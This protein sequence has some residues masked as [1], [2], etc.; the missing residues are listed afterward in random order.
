MY[1]K[2]FLGIKGETFQTE[3]IFSG[4]LPSMAM[5]MLIWIYCCTSYY[6]EEAVKIA[7]LTVAHQMAMNNNDAVE[8]QADSLGA[9][10]V[11]VGTDAETATAQAVEEPEF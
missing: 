10:S 3:I 8:A 4:L 11:G 6:E 2:F 7:A 5:F 1:C 9:E